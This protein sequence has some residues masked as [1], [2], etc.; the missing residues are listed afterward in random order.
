M[1]EFFNQ[2]IDDAK[3]IRLAL[4]VSQLPFNHSVD[5]SSPASEVSQFQIATKRYQQHGEGGTWPFSNL[6]TN[7]T[8]LASVEFRVQEISN[9]AAQ[10]PDGVVYLRKH[11][12]QKLSSTHYRTV[13]EAESWNW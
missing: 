5:T 6:I 9:Y 7:G 3:S 1:E 11:S 4:I 10:I 12:S 13:R 2:R 8:D